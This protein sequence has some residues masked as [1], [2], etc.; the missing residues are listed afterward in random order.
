MRI[1][2]STLLLSALLPLVSMTS[3]AD[4]SNLYGG[5]LIAHEVTIIPRSIDPPPQGWC[6]YYIDEHAIY[7][8]SDVDARVDVDTVDFV[9]WYILAAWEGEDK[10][11]CGT[12][13]GFGNYDA[14]CFTY[15]D[16]FPCFPDEGLEIPTSGWPGP[17]E[18]TA[19]VTTTEPWMGN[20][21]PVYFFDGYVYGYGV[22]TQIQIDEDPATGF[23]GFG[24]CETP[25]LQ[26]TL[27][28]IGR[29]ALGINTDGVVP[30]FE[31]LEPWAC[32]FADGHCEMI[33]EYLCYPAGGVEWLEGVPCDPNPCPQPEGACC[34]IGHCSVVTEE[35]C[36]LVGG[37]WLGM[38]TTCDPNPCPAVC[39]YDI[40]GSYQHLCAIVT[41]AECGTLN[42]FW[43]PDWD[44]C[45]PNPCS[46]FSPAERVSWGRIKNLYR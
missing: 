29:G 11:W 13:F 45:D 5:V 39:C 10:Q 42:G 44:C 12:E 19:F 40:V 22:S 32:C 43:F 2:I 37:E 23:V 27:F 17:N 18:G 26:Y 7:S 14:S 8:L 38:G 21:L 36:D 16:A 9:V 28:P 41:Q 25:P 31:Q 15:M 20:W 35:E 4:P 33:I 34:V 1:L 24:N 30:Q 3:L 6:Q 46:I